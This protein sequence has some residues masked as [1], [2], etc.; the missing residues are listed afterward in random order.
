MT[1]LAI[2]RCNICGNIVQKFVDGAG[3][4]VCC[5]EQMEELMPQTNEQNIMEKHVPIF[6]KN[7]DGKTEIRV[8]E[9]LHPM[10][11]EHYIMF[12]E[13]ISADNKHIQIDFLSDN[14]EPKMHTENNDYTK[15]LEYCNI[16]GLWEGHND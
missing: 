12:I 14:D 3:E 8:G 6:I 2:Y 9:V 5:G 13:A 15:A 1:H 7:Q 4:L 10:E 11:K 16:H